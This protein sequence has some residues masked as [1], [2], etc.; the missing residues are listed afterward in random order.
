MNRKFA[1][2]VFCSLV[3]G[4]P[5]MADTIHVRAGGDIHAAIEAASS[6]DTIQLASGHYYLSY[7]LNTLGK[8][9]TLQG[10]L[11]AAGVTRPNDS[12]P[13]TTIHSN[14][15]WPVL[16]VSFGETATFQYLHITDGVAFD[17]GFG[18]GLEV[19]DSNAVVNACKF[20]HNLA[21]Q[22][23]G[24]IAALDGSTAIVT[25]SYL[26]KNASMINK[27]GAVFA[28]KTS[29]ANV[30]ASIIC[31]NIVNPA[32]CASSSSQLS[33]SY[34]VEGTEISC[35]GCEASTAGDLNHDGLV[36]G[37]DLTVVLSTWGNSAEGYGACCHTTDAGDE[38]CT[39]TYEGY[40]ASVYGGT[41]YEGASC[42]DPKV[43]CNSQF[44]QNP[45][46]FGV[47]CYTKNNTV[48][49]GFMTQ[50]DCTQLTGTFFIGVTNCNLLTEAQ[51][52]T[53]K[54]VACCGCKGITGCQYLPEANCTGSGC[55]SPLTG[56]PGCVLPEGYN[57]ASPNT[58]VFCPD[59]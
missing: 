50:A 34:S 33:G 3:M 48:S 37:A 20:D 47:C 57:C 10:A 42:A 27:G 22:Q 9:V 14:G 8:D 23:G 2:T 18:G 25:N 1:A 39:L 53:G 13:T 26:F 15:P 52:A 19:V 16:H 51:C 56:A 46:S 12:W 24:A 28:D 29:I 32:G 49:C 30:D 4:L 11:P 36:D 54:V 5:A 59:C 44:L 38:I 21:G 35:T 7:P 17:N 41:F 55:N 6:G 31:G 45:G 58:G 43:P 40:C